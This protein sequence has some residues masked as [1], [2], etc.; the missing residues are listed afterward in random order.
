MK[1]ADDILSDTYLKKIKI[2]KTNGFRTRTT[3]TNN[4]KNRSKKD[5]DIN[6]M[7][8]ASISGD[9]M[10]L[11][12][13]EITIKDPNEER[14]FDAL[15]IGYWASFMRLIIK[16]FLGTVDR[17]YQIKF[18]S[19]GD[20]YKLIRK[21]YT[22]DPMF[23]QYEEYTDSRIRYKLDEVEDFIEKINI[24]MKRHPLLKKTTNYNI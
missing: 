16:Q 21:V 18:T 9:V 24:F 22:N 23:K 4:Y 2:I 15:D 6:K 13:I 10:T 14:N 3:Y 1:N 19:H 8:R 17:A 7:I 20:M 11:D 5:K 12:T